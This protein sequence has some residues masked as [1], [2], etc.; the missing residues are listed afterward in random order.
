MF[1]K[2][3]ITFFW[4]TKDILRNLCS[5][6]G[7][8]RGPILFGSS[9]VLQN[10]IHV[11]NQTAGWINVFFGELSLLRFSRITKIF[12]DLNQKERE[13]E[14]ETGALLV[15]D[16]LCER[17]GVHYLLRWNNTH[18]S[19]PLCIDKTKRIPKNVL[20][21]LL[22]LLE[23]NCISQSDGQPLPTREVHAKPW[24]HVRCL[25]DVISWGSPW[26]SNLLC[27]I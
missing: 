23:C 19:R 13:R 25:C 17:N 11:C 12:L 3:C 24:P 26:T 14:K 8:Q 6:N 4:T 27:M 16:L 2:T 15:E 18:P 7:S 21:E 1:S 22:S 9:T 20:C 5:F 10:I